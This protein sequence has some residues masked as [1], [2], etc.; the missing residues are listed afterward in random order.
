[1]SEIRN[2]IKKALKELILQYYLKSNK[3]IKKQ[4]LIDF[5]S[6]KG[7]KK[8]KKNL[9]SV[10]LEQAWNSLNLNYGGPKLTYQSISNIIEVD[11]EIFLY[12]KEIVSKKT[13][14]LLKKNV[15]PKN[16]QPDPT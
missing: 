12:F 9:P 14:N 13:L 15:S 10:L 7:I 4:I 2:E 8:I 11:D 1:M 16:E 3:K 6:E 5:K